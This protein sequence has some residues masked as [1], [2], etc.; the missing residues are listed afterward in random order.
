M[1]TE[2]DALV[3][4][5][6]YLTQRGG[7]ERVVDVVARAFPRAPL[8]TSLYEPSSTFEGFA[9][10]VVRT[11]ILNRLPLL[12]R[13]HR[14]ALPL[15]APWFSSQVV[16]ADVVFASSSGWAHEVRTDGR[17]VVY[18]HAPARWLYQSERYLRSTG[19]PSTAK[20]AGRLALAVLAPP[21]RAA[22]RAAA[23][24]ADAYL[25]NSTATAALVEELY[26][27]SAEVLHPP[28]GLVPG[29]AE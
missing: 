6:D 8:L 22:D 28:P 16:R 23:R 5:H 18:C 10:H 13:H 12:R 15:L 9:S 7:A 14:L 1:P 26:G 4:V 20:T 29:G 19:A 3:L 2:P 11:G 24:R 21:L 27:R 17:L 25:A